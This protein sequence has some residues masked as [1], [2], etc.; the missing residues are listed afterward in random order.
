MR[1]RVPSLLRWIAVLGLCLATPSLD[2]V[3]DAAVSWATDGSCCSDEGCDSGAPCQQQCCHC[4]PSLHAV[5]SSDWATTATRVE[6]VE[7]LF[8]A[9]SATASSGHHEPPFRPPSV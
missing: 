4:V 5:L 7:P 6:Q 8:W 2:D 3:V 9:A 1:R